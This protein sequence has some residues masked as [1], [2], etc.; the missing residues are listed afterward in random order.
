MV[1]SAPP[2]ECLDSRTSGSRDALPIGV[3]ELDVIDA[4][5]VV[6]REKTGEIMLD[7]NNVLRAFIAAD[8]GRL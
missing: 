1:S 6:L 7:L 4:K 3:G 8:P 2:I 5:I